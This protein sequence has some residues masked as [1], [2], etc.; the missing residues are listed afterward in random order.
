MHVVR[1][2]HCRVATVMPRPSVV[3]C[4]YAETVGDFGYK[5]T[6]LGYLLDYFS[7]EIF[8]KRSLLMAPPCGAKCEALEVTREDVEFHIN[9]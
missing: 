5:V 9:V 7:L 6:A 8:G 4:R 3:V 2:D 1:R